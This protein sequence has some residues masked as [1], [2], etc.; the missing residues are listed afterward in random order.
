MTAQV[1]SFKKA[2]AKRKKEEEVVVSPTD[3][4]SNHDL[5]RDVVDQ[6]L[7]EWQAAAERNMLS[8]YIYS[9]LPYLARGPRNADYVNDL[10]VISKIE[11]KLGMT[12]AVFSPGATRNNAIGW[13]AAFHREQEI[14]GCP[15]DMA[16]ESMARALNIVL[17]L[18]YGGL[19]KSLGRK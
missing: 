13:V 4:K 14:L 7:G 1:I 8:D 2:A 9:K 12:V 3:K 17:F 18:V 19:L 15:P 10:N 16:S 6:V 11:N 5:F